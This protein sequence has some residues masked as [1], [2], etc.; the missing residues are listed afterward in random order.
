MLVYCAG[1]QEF[2]CQR[3]PFLI[4]I[5]SKTFSIKFWGSNPTE[6][7]SNTYLLNRLI[8]ISVYPIIW[9]KNWTDTLWQKMSLI[10]PFIRLS[11]NSKH[12]HQVASSLVT[13]L[14]IKIS[15]YLLIQKIVN[16]GRVPNTCLISRLI[17]IS[18]YPLIQVK[19]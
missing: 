13:T 16:T 9:V 18:V 2:K 1:G 10:Y 8:N 3:L 15:I 12:T 5:F 6:E 7:L 17:K 4:F 14:L 11:S 19:S